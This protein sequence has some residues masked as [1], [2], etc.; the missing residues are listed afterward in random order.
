MKHQWWPS[1]RSLLTST[2]QI[3]TQEPQ[4]S[5]SRQQGRVN[6]E[7]FPT[8]SLPPP[9]YL[10]QAGSNR[11]ELVVILKSCIWSLVPRIPLF[12]ISSLLGL[13]NSMLLFKDAVESS[14]Y[15]FIL[16]QVLSDLAS[17]FLYSPSLSNYTHTL[18]KWSLNYLKMSFIPQWEFH[19]WIP[20]PKG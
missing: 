10:G 18:V 15:G 6:K 3:L 13:I 19:S 1:P 2:R 4:R 16:A 7:V 12:Q 17:T 20:K 5:S 11:L 9:S 8:G 14:I